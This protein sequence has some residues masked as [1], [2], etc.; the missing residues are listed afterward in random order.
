MSDYLLNINPGNQFNIVRCSRSVAILKLAFQ[1]VTIRMYHFKHGKKLRR[2]K[3]GLNVKSMESERD[4][5]KLSFKTGQKDQ[6]WP[7]LL[8]LFRVRIEITSISKHDNC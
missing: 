6:Y 8:T 3:T 1:R 7:I 2:I 4:K 5:E